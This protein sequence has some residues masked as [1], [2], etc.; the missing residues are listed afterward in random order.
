MVR[1]HEGL[2]DLSVYSRYFHHLALSARVTHD[3]LTRIC[4]VDYDREMVLVAES[5]AGD[6]VAV[7][8]LT[9]EQDSAEAE[10]ALLVSDAWQEHGLGTEL[11]RRLVSL[12]RGEGI[13]RVFG[14][15]LPENRLMQEVCRQLGFELQYSKDEGFVVGSVALNP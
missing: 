1:F 14:N 7:G 10:F 11:L 2:T 5:A 13:A 12:A 3:R 4:F 8:R 9:R 6:I 15:I